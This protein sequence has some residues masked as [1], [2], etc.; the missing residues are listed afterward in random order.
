MRTR[1]F[2][3]V[4]KTRDS[5]CRRCW[6]CQPTTF[7]TK[8]DLDFTFSRIRNVITE[9]N[10]NTIQYA[11]LAVQPRVDLAN[12]CVVFDPR[13]TACCA[14]SVHYVPHRFENCSEMTIT[15]TSSHYGIP[16]IIA[17]K[18]TRR[19]T[20]PILFFPH[21]CTSQN[22]MRV[23]ILYKAAATP[24]CRLVRYYCTPSL[25]KTVDPCTTA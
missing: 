19:E 15:I 22:H 12:R 5:W 2:S 20:V 11:N 4:D 1:K 7:P 17:Y 21:N 8:N 13:V 24:P 9:D 16:R 3:T 14:C 25:Q 10:S 18:S 23:Y 6:C